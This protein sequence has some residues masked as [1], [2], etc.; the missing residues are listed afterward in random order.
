MVEDRLVLLHDLDALWNLMPS[1]YVDQLKRFQDGDEIR[2]ALTTPHVNSEEV[3]GRE[4]IGGVSSAMFH[5]AGS[6]I[7]KTL[8]EVR[9]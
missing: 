8:R 4:R 9:C 2:S 5:V 7:G 3:S 1:S 6:G